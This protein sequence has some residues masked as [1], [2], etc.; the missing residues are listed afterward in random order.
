[1]IPLNEGTSQSQAQSGVGTTLLNRN[2]TIREHYH[3]HP[4]GN[5]RPSN[6]DKTFAKDVR[7]YNPKASFYINVFQRVNG[8]TRLTK[9][10]Y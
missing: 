1:M 3:N 2:Y 7:K 10:A 6:A 8:R 9:N 5:N 4:S